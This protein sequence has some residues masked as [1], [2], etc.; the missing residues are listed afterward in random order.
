[1]A[2]EW[3]HDILDAERI[4]KLC[5]DCDKDCESCSRADRMDCHLEVREAVH[6]LAIHFKNAILSMLEE[7]KKEKVMAP[8][9]PNPFVS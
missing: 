3:A 5:E 8:E 4:I 6:S 2:I 9:K 7:S 1:M